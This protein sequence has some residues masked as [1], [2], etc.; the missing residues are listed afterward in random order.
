MALS[1]LAGRE[2]K[3]DDLESGFLDPPDSAKPRVYW[4]WLESNVSKA[5]ITRDLEEMRAKGIGGALIFDAAS[6]V[7]G[8]PAGPTFMSREWR[9][10]FKHAVDEAGRLDLELSVNICSGWDSGGP[11]VPPQFA[12]QKVVWSETVVEGPQSLERP[13]PIA[14]AVPTDAN[15]KPIFYRDIAVQAFPIVESPP[16]AM[17]RARPKVTASSS[18]PPY[19]P[20]NVLDGKADTLWVSSGD[21]A[22]AGPSQESPEWLRF[23]FARPFP[24]ASFV[25]VPQDG[26]GPRACELQSSEDGENFETVCRFS[27]AREGAKTVAFK[28]FRSRIFRLVIDGAF[29]DRSIGNPWNVQIREVALLR[30]GEIHA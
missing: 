2:S 20:H 23:E 5:G 19:P 26:Y 6:L 8:T 21:R 22:G 10:R 13:L 7:K 27:L 16:S 3:S 15:G 29:C 11:W 24:A 12:S 17:Q 30:D 25:I 28:K 1:I 18:Q 9:D 4:W 14:G